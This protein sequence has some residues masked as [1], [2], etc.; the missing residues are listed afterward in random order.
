MF[1]ILCVTTTARYN[2]TENC[3]RSFQGKQWSFTL[4]L[5]LMC[6]VCVLYRIDALPLALERERAT[7]LHN[8]ARQAL[9]LIR[10]KE[11][12]QLGAGAY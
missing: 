1:K 11:R 3:S 9:Q 2:S 7:H 5:F 10:W 4:L 8:V 6:S 12:P